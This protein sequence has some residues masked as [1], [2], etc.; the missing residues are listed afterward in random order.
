MYECKCRRCQEVL[1]II[2]WMSSF[3]ARDNRLCSSCLS[4]EQKD[5]YIKHRKI[6][7]EKLGG[8][9]E[10]CGINDFD[11]LSIDHIYGGGHKER[12]AGARGKTHMA[13]LSRISEDE[14]RTK[15]RCLCFNCN[16]CIGFYGVCQHDL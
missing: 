3:R 2:N 12:I 7:L 5:R 8:K 15:Y 16:C 10:C 4:I 1:T 11:M 14:L 9:C 13:K 6:V